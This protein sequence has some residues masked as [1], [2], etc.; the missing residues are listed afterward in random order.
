MDCFMADPWAHITRFGIHDET[1]PSLHE[2]DMAS[3]RR[4]TRRPLARTYHRRAS[5]ISSQVARVKQA[6]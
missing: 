4:P 2:V 3:T 1:F 6:K 5:V